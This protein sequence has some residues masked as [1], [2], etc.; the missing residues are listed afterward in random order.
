MA[1]EEAAASQVAEA[2]QA[3]SEPLS[4]DDATNDTVFR[5]KDAWGFLQRLRVAQDLYSEEYK[6]FPPPPGAARHS[7]GG[8]IQHHGILGPIQGTASRI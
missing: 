7:R 1:F 5:H 4:E 2:S 6:R 3:G 8:V